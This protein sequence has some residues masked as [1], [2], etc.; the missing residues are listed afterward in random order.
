LLTPKLKVW[1]VV[2]AIGFV[3]LFSF[4]L[5]KFALSRNQPIAILPA[6]KE[7]HRLTGHFTLSPTTSIVAR[8]FSVPVGEMLAVRLRA[9]TG[10]DVPV[11]LEEVQGAKT[12]DSIVFTTQAADTTLGPEGYTLSVAKDSVTVRAVDQAGFFYGMQTFLQL[13]PPSIYSN[14]PLAAQHWDLP[15]LRIVDKPR[16]PWRGFMLDVSRH[17]FTPPEIKGLLDVMALHKL[18]TFHWHLT[19]DQGWRIEIKKYPRLTSVG[20]WRKAVGFNLDPKS[21]TAYGP[22]GRYGGFYSQADVRDIIAYA[23]AR[24]ISIVPEIDVPGHSS[25]ALAAYPQ[26]SCSG[27][28]YSTDMTE[29]IAPGIFCPG[30]EETF[31][32]LENVLSEIMD[33]FPCQFIHI[34]GDEVS[35]QNW[36]GCP[37]CRERMTQEGM[38]DAAE[39]QH[40]FTHRIE[41]FVNS[42]GRRALGWSEVLTGDLVPTTVIMDWTGGGPE[43]LLKGHQVVMSP[44]EY[45]YLDLYQSRNRLAEPPAAGAYLP[46]QK[47]YNFEPMPAGLTLEQQRRVL[48][49]QANLWTEYVSSLRHAEY[50]AF[51]RLCALA[52]VVWT[53]KES[54]HWHNF[55]RRLVIHE[56]R[57]HQLGINYRRG[58]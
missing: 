16:F 4:G 44:E 52:E 24:H 57:L 23:Q 54:R 10:F 3:I 55:T 19:D 47:V 14:Q 27:G 13:L 46:L 18:N 7:L 1:V 30:K 26:F 35:K 28:P 12:Q 45:C 15:C 43:A 40:Y 20:A 41:R 29:A 9:A 53:P 49:S 6:A 38:T 56:Q 42:H 36:R 32:F 11:R 25:A 5:W 58:E 21:T 31:G 17:F 39:L 22:D 33:L 37:K 8:E 2:L 34:G 50:M 48:G 51:P